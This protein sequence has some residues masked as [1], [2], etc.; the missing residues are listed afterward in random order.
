MKML[1]LPEVL[2]AT[3]LSRATVYRLEKKGEFPKRRRLGVNSVGWVEE[4]VTL[5][6]S[7]DV[8]LAYTPSAASFQQSSAQPRAQNAR[9]P[10]QTDPTLARSW[11]APSLLPATSQPRPPPP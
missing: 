8:T 10:L 7:G 2:E 1:R 6:V 11:I 9:R 3:G 4:E 5:W